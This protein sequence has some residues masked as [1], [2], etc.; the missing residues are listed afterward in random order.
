MSQSIAASTLSVGVGGSPSSMDSEVPTLSH[1]RLER[2]RLEGET[3]HVLDCTALM[4][5][6]QDET[7]QEQSMFMTSLWVA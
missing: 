1:H 7:R 5:T 2:M 3:H 6:R 4:M